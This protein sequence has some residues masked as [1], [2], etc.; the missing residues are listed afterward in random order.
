MK[1]VTTH[2]L[3]ETLINKKWKSIASSEDKTSILRDYAVFCEEEPAN[4]YRVIRQDIVRE[5][6]AQST[7]VRQS[8]FDFKD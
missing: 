4:S 1:T 3:L 6:I 5:S 7:D 2:Y 8:T